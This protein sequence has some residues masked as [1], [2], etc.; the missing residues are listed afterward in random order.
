MPSE[1]LIS[2]VARPTSI[3]CAR[4]MLTSS[5]TRVP[6]RCNGNDERER[7]VGLPRLDR[8]PR[9]LV[10]VLDH[11]VGEHRRELQAGQDTGLHVIGVVAPRPVGERARRNRQ[12]AI[13]L[14]RL[15]AASSGWWAR[16]RRS[17]SGRHVAAG[18]PS[19]VT[20]RGRCSLAATTGAAAA[21]SAAAGVAPRCRGVRRLA[22]AG[23][24][25]R[26]CG[27]RRGG[28]RCAR[29]GRCGGR[30]RGWCS[31][32]CRR[33]RRRGDVVAGLRLVHPH[34][35]VV[36]VSHRP[37]VAGRPAVHEGM[38]VDAGHAPLGH[39][40]QLEVREEGQL[41]EENRI[42]VRILRRRAAVGVEQRL[43]LVQ[44]VHDRRVR[45]EVPVG[46]G[47]HRHLRQVDVAVV[48]VEDVLA[49]IRHARHATAA[50]TSATA[51]RRRVAGGLAAGGLRCAPPRPPA[52]GV[53]QAQLTIAVEPVDVAVA[54]VGIGHRCDRDEDV[55]A[56]LLDERRRLGREPVGQ[57]HQHFGRP[58]LA[59]VEPA[60][61]V[62]LR[63]GRGDQLTDLGRRAA[64]R[65]R[66]ACRGCRGSSSGSRCSRP[67]RSR[68]RRARG[69][70]RTCRSSRS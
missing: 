11:Q 7:R 36:V 64:A 39:L 13:P 8:I 19:L 9:L 46:D 32:R 35:A 70:R 2:P 26:R 58:G 29:I 33:R 59:A 68:R 53:E 27:T 47:A 48:V 62:V 40:R 38:R 54:S 1:I 57:L 67:T 23:R 42:E 12:P 21:S 31:R 52:P 69:L 43:R 3:P 10:E 61:Q 16:G 51:W 60:H 66:D 63:P 45:G 17:A 15:A 50:A 5:A 65:I 30:C 6:S 34:H 49:P 14:A 55:V 28:R 41:G 4:R 25:G 24:I 22:A 44:V 18:A 37:E 20:F 56:D